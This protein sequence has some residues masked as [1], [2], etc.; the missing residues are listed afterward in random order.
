MDAD[1]ERI[2][3]AV[4]SSSVAERLKAEAERLKAFITE[5]EEA[6]INPYDYVNTD[7]AESESFRRDMEKLVEEGAADSGSDS[8]DEG[9]QNMVP[10]NDA[11]EQVKSRKVGVWKLEYA[12]AL[13]SSRSW[14][15]SEVVSAIIKKGASAKRTPNG[16]AVRSATM[17][18][19]DNQQFTVKVEGCL[20]YLMNTPVGV[21]LVKL[22]S[23]FHPSD[24]GE[25]KQVFIE[26]SRVLR[27]RAVLE[28]CDRANDLHQTIEGHDGKK[29][30]SSSAGTKQIQL[31]IEQ[32]QQS[33]KPE[34]YH[35]GDVFF[36]GNAANL[37]GAVYWVTQASEND[38]KDMSFVASLVNGVKD[39][40]PI[41]NLR[42]LDHVVVG[43]SFSDTKG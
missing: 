39:K 37:I 15:P 38:M 10:P 24:E 28:V 41:T 2:H 36:I 23:I 13:A 5:C 14:K 20:F 22:E 34:L 40:I 35:W 25:Q 27:G 31:Q 4:P 3:S 33:G 9:M 17:Q 18:R 42:Q 21:E 1:S 6:G 26:Y 16:T 11:F 30:I 29:I 43:A 7:P 19:A 8:E 32:R 12:V